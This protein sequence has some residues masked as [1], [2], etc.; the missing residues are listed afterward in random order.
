MWIIIP[1]D[2]EYGCIFCVYVNCQ[3]VCKESNKAVIF[4]Y[5][6]CLSFLIH[7]FCVCFLNDKR[8]PFLM[9]P[10]LLFLA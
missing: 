1:L 2:G 6:N 3:E 10:D 4:V 9:H 5:R 8:L 7:T